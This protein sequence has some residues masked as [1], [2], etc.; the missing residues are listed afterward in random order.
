MHSIL[1][2]LA[3]VF[4]SSCATPQ[5]RVSYK[6]PLG[7]Q[8]ELYFFLQPLPQEVESLS[9]VLSEISAVPVQGEAIPILASDMLIEGSEYVG[10][11]KRLAAALLPPGRYKGIVLSIVRAG[12][13]T[14]EGEVDLLPPPSPVRLELDFSIQ[15]G[16]AHALF[17][18]L[19]SEFLV[20]EGYRFTPR[21]VLGKPFLPPRNYTGFVSL[22]DENIVAVFNKKTMEIVQVIHTGTGP[23]GMALDQRNGTVYVAAAGSDDIDIINLTTMSIIGR[24]RMRSGDAPREIVLTPDGRTLLAVNS[25]SGTVSLIDTRSQSERARFILD[26]DPVWIVMGE[27]GQ[28][29]FVLHALTNTL[30]ILDV[31][32]QELL[33]AITLDE[34]PWRGALGRDGDNLFIV[35]QYTSDLLVLDTDSFVETRRVFTGGGASSITVDPRNSLVYVGTSS[36]EVVVVDPDA[37]MYIDSFP[38]ERDTEHLAIDGEENTLLVLSGQAGKLQKFNLVSKKMTAGLDTGSRGYALVVMGEL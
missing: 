36:A 23:M 12:K 4:V 34:S 6:P 38:V 14:E 30:S 35:P 24:I 13:E 11:Q 7:D 1:L 25:G 8:G 19:S 9:F 37:G 3:M 32:R 33:A 28:S 16:R 17:L 29:A 2:L 31:R 27:T 5:E 26:P 21:F 10:R 20:R 18:F 22:P 15:R